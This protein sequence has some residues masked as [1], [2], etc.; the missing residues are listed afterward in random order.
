MMDWHDRQRPKI[1][2]SPGIKVRITTTYLHDVF[3]LEFTQMHSSWAWFQEQLNILPGKSRDCQI[4]VRAPTSGTYCKARSSLHPS[5]LFRSCDRPE[6]LPA[7]FVRSKPPPAP[8]EAFLTGRKGPG[9][10]LTVANRAE[11]AL[12]GAVRTAAAGRRRVATRHALDVYWAAHLSGA[13]N[14]PRTLERNK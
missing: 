7:R 3:A 13:A 11:T 8:L 12:T 1:T 2:S 6:R 9:R 14:K 5:A 4:T 10:A